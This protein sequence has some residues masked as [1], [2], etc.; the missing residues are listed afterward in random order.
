MKVISF[1]RRQQ[2]AVEFTAS[3]VVSAS[4]GTGKTRTLVG[5]YL[6]LLRSGLEPE[7][8]LASTVTDKA[9]AEMR[10]RVRQQILS[11]LGTS[12]ENPQRDTLWR[13]K[14]AK[15]TTAP[16]STIHSFCG[17]LLRENALK[18]DVDPL[19]VVMDEVTASAMRRPGPTRTTAARSRSIFTA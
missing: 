2:Q 10:D 8:I 17:R 16:V 14:L 18:A 9:A 12:G 4:A 3:T 6:K 19:F 7:Q 5:L 11:E 13:Q 1:N 15:I